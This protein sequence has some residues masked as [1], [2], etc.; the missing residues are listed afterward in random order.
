[1]PADVLPNNAEKSPASFRSA[2]ANLQTYVEQHGFSGINSHYQPQ[3]QL[4]DAFKKQACSAFTVTLLKQEQERSWLLCLLRAMGLALKDASTG[5]N[6]VSSKG[7]ETIWPIDDCFWRPPNETCSWMIRN[8]PESTVQRMRR[9]SAPRGSQAKIRNY[10]DS[11]SAS[12]IY[13]IFKS[14]F[15]TFRYSAHEW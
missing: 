7:F 4:L 10:Y 13:Q 9:L 15:K 2:V 6:H 3:T 14:D 12:S 5:F 1:M 8:W 11:S